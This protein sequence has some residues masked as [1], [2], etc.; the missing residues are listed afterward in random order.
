ML[1]VSDPVYLCSGCWEKKDTSAFNQWRKLAF[2]QCKGEGQTKEE[3]IYFLLSGIL[4]AHLLRVCFRSPS[5]SSLEAH[6]GLL[7]CSIFLFLPFFLP[8]FNWLSNHMFNP[9]QSMS[10]HPNSYSIPSYLL[11]LA[12]LPNFLS[13]PSLCLSYQSF[14][15]SSI[16]LFL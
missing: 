5:N 16:P 1:G 10:F 8:L 7:C 6:S 12:Y 9:A 13:L 15:T 3:S 2:P 14:F 4:W 11:S